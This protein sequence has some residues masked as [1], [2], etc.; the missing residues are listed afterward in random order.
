MMTIQQ[1]DC[2]MDA[3]VKS[4]KPQSHAV[5]NENKS[6]EPTTS[7]AVTLSCRTALI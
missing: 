2:N 1:K 4:E 3:K 5:T 6:C 7:L